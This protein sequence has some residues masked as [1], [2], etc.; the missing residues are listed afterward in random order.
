LKLMSA[1]RIDV[2]DLL[3]HPGARRPLHV[4]AAVADLGGTAAR[5]DEP[6]AVDLVLERVPDGLVARGNVHAHWDAQCSTCLQDLSGELELAVAELF[7]TSPAEGETY[8]IE[9]GHMIDLEL[10]VRDAVLLELPLAPSCRSVEGR[11]CTPVV[12]LGVSFDEPYDDEPGEAP[13]DPR[14]AALS[15]LEL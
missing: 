7:E 1:L 11:E 9:N 14:W 10:L 8:P 4:E 13:A 12:P 6:V 2:A 3:T 5:V 15:E